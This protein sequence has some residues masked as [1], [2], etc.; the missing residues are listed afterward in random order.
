[1]VGQ[2]RNGSVT[3]AKTDNIFTSICTPTAEAGV[4][5]SVDF[6][7]PHL[8]EGYSEIKDTGNYQDNI[9]TGIIFDESGYGYNGGQLGT[10]EVSNDTARYNNSIN[11]NGT[12]D[13]ILTENLPLSNVIN[14]EI[15]YS[16]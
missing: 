12:D 13:G 15:T 9:E 10:L 14:S 1:V 11:F 4:P 2:Y 16:F 5:I 3:E 6:C 7:C 8:I